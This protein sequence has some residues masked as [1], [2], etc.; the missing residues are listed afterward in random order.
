MEALGA[1]VIAARDIR[2]LRTARAD[3]CP[4]SDSVRLAHHERASRVVPP[5]S[6][7]GA[8]ASRHA[9]L[10]LPVRQDIFCGDGYRP[11][12]VEAVCETRFFLVD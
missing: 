6:A 12:N 5:R 7:S 4:R 2:A 9:R 8:P 1:L 3:S 10:A 11:F